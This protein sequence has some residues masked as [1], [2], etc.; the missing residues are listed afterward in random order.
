MNILVPIS[1]GELYDKISILEIKME[2]IKDTVKLDNVSK[3]L[4]QL[5]AI[6]KSCPISKELYDNLKDVNLR[7]WFIEDNIREKEREH[8]Y[9]EDFINLARK[10]YITN[11]IR[12]NIKKEINLTY[13]SDLIEEKSYEKY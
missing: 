3:E 10:V 6:A 13:G 1:L 7:L 11:D 12:S 8:L 2:Q 4:V 5:K 9:D